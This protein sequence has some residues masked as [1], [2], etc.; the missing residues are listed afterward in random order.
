MWVSRVILVFSSSSLAKMNYFYCSLVKMSHFIVL[1]PIWPFQNSLLVIMIFNPKKI[2]LPFLL[3]PSSSSF[4]NNIPAASSS[5]STTKHHLQDHWMYTHEAREMP[6]SDISVRHFIKHLAI[7]NSLSTPKS[8]K[9]I[10]HTP[11]P[12]QLLISS[13]TNQQIINSTLPF[14]PYIEKQIK[15]EFKFQSMSWFDA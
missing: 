2:P 1:W 15:N 14:S 8:P 11:I 5:N 10:S 7:I 9:K 12:F 13:Q 4:L 3:P 6:D